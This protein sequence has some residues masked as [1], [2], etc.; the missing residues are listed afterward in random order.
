M[1]ADISMKKC[2][3]ILDCV[4][5]SIFSPNT[6]AAQPNMSEVITCFLSGAGKRVI[7]FMINKENKEINYTFV[8]EGKAELKVNFDGNKK[9]KQLVDNEMQVTYYGFNRGK[10]SYVIN[11]INGSEKEDYTMSFNVKKK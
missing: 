3:V 11:V 4:L 5:Y 1:R 8:K 7:T 6:I 2:R 9:L 10:Y